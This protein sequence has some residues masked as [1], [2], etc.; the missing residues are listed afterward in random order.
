MDRLSL[1]SCAILTLVVTVSV[2]MA[3]VQQAP[4]G[5]VVGQDPP[6]A[7]LRSVL[8]E[9]IPSHTSQDDEMSQPNR[10]A[11]PRSLSAQ[12]NDVTC[13][14]ASEGND[15]TAEVEMG[16]YTLQASFAC[17]EALTTI[18][19]ADN[20][21]T[22]CLAQPADSQG[23]PIKTVLGVDGSFK[24]FDS[25]QRYTVTLNKMPGRKKVMYYKCS[26]GNSKTCTVTVRMPKKPDPSK[27][28]LETG[29][30]GSGQADGGDQLALEREPGASY[31][32]FTAA[33]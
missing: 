33:G 7:A 1:I 13:P 28:N 31:V 18:S 8:D 11:R 4:A 16:E 3:E 6:S 5:A 29:M 21:G 14:A 23:T 12:G 20:D 26:D 32:V 2:C 10:P 9:G 27:S 30:Q 24:R 22:K 15:S 25:T 19:P 17:A